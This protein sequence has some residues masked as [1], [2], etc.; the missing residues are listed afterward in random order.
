MKNSCPLCAEN[1]VGEYAKDRD[2]IY[3]QCTN[4]R[5]VFVPV[6]YHISSNDEKARYDLHQNNLHDD[7]YRKFLQRIV[8]PV[9]LH[10]QPQAKGL[11]FGSGPGPTLSLLFAE[12]GY[13]MDLYD[14]FYAKN[15][16][17]W[18]KH[19]DFITATEVV[20]HLKHPYQELKRLFS[21]LNIASPLAIMTKLIT[22]QINFGKWSYKNDKTHISF[23]CKDTFKWL[24]NKLHA[25]LIFMENDIIILIKE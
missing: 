25:R 18:R 23:F 6:I 19:Y 17:V 5:L 1:R 21:I 11:D 9:T 22:P 13:S 2:R 20:E 15:E 24:A 7:G 10:L 12:L 8:K 16:I 3:L 4:C 14:C